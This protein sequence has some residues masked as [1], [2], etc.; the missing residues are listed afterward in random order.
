MIIMPNVSIIKASILNVNEYVA[1]L[2][3]S[4]I[5]YNGTSAI[6]Y[7]GSL[8]EMRTLYYNL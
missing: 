6:Q 5:K 4:S 8:G 2:L 7:T 1:N 3:M